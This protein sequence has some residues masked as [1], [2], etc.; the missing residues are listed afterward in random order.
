[1]ENLEELICT[2]KTHMEHSPW[3]SRAVD[4]I[5]YAAPKNSNFKECENVN[6]YNAEIEKVNS[7][8]TTKFQLHIKLLPRIRSQITMY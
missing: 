7:Q 2:Y 5:N 1:M 4:I 8:H 6:N 3:F